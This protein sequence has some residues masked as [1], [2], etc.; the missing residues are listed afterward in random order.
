M[1]CIILRSANPKTFDGGSCSMIALLF[2]DNDEGPINFW[3]CVIQYFVDHSP[4]SLIV[5]CLEQP[6]GAIEMF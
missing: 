3:S 4:F 2:T 5:P 6:S 1:K